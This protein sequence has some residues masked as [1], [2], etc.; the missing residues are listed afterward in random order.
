[1]DENKDKDEDDGPSGVRDFEALQCSR[2]KNKKINRPGNKFLVRTQ[3]SICSDA[4][5]KNK[6]SAS[7]WMEVASIQTQNFLRYIYLPREV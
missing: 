4:K 6:N 7:M 5:N 1:M 3:T 2:E